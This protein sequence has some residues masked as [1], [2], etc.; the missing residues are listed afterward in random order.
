K[1]GNSTV[2]PAPLPRRTHASGTTKLARRLRQKCGG[3]SPAIFGTRN[4]VFP[5]E[6]CILAARVRQNS[7]EFWRTRRRRRPTL[8]GWPPRPCWPPLALCYL[9]LNRVALRTAVH[10]I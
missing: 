2:S 9:E 10:F 6:N 8:A 7:R 4:R 1:S 3:L 5:R